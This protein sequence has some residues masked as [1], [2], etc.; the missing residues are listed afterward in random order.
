MAQGSSFK[1]EHFDDDDSLQNQFRAPAKQTLQAKQPGQG[2]KGAKAK[3]GGAK[4]I[5]VRDLPDAGPARP[6]DREQQ[7]PLHQSDWPLFFALMPSF[8]RETEF[9]KF[10]SEEIATARSHPTSRRR[11]IPMANSPRRRARCNR[12]EA[13]AGIVALMS[14]LSRTAQQWRSGPS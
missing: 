6:R 7:F 10:V 12:H 4:L 3:D 5:L 13:R 14:C 8:S 1:S 11:R 2:S 9:T